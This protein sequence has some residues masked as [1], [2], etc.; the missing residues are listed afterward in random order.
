MAGP[1]GLEPATSCVT[2]SWAKIPSAFFGVACE[3]EP[4]LTPSS[5]VRSLSVAL[6]HTT[7]FQW[8]RD[9][10]IAEMAPGRPSDCQRAGDNFASGPAACCD[11]RYG[12]S[13]DATSR[14][15]A[16]F[17]LPASARSMMACISSPVSFSPWASL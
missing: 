1:T 17:T 15:D 4:S 10:L 7:T 3:Q 16:F 12:F 11:T 5:M 9:Q 2:V 13:L 8:G 14:S 6:G